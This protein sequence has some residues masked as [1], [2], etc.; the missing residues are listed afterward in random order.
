MHEETRTQVLAR[1][2]VFLVV[3]DGGVIPVRVE[4]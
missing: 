4:E 1:N 2:L 3:G